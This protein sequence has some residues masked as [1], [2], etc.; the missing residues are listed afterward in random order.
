MYFVLERTFWFRD[1]LQQYFS[2]FTYVLHVFP[3][4]GKAD[5]RCIGDTQFYTG[6]RIAVW[7]LDQMFWQFLYMS[8]TELLRKYFPDVPQF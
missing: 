2:Q 3:S 7:T 1:M 4:L 5:N 8:V 6:R